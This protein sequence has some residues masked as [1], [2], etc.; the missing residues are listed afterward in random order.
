MQSGLLFLPCPSTV[1]SL[2]TTDIHSTTEVI[3]GTDIDESELPAP[4]EQSV[5]NSSAPSDN[6]QEQSLENIKI[7]SKADALKSRFS[8]NGRAIYTIVE[9]SEEN[10]RTATPPPP[11]K[12]Q[13]THETS[14]ENSRTATQALPNTRQ[15]KVLSK[16]ISITVEDRD[17]GIKEEIFQITLDHQTGQTYTFEETS[18]DANEKDIAQELNSQEEAKMKESE[19]ETPSNRVEAEDINLDK[20][21]A[22]PEKQKRIN[23]L[24]ADTGIKGRVTILVNQVQIGKVEACVLFLT[25]SEMRTSQYSGTSKCHM[26]NP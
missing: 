16:S 18:T 2:N 23:E 20:K 11:I 19:N 26:S 25:H 3:S 24:D 6:K 14:E 10:S 5:L 1:D 21:C 7:P 13:T 8:Q 15:K 17:T 12:K 22:K 4:P 9:T